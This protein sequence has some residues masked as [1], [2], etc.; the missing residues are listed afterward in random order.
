M[1]VKGSQ[2]RPKVSEPRTSDPNFKG[3]QIQLVRPPAQFL[4]PSMG[5]CLIELSVWVGAPVDV[6]SR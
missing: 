2:P 4:G 6:G 1:Q 5:P 3:F